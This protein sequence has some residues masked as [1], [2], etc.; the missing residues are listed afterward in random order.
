MDEFK[1]KFSSWLWM[2]CMAFFM[3][4]TLLMMPK[5]DPPVIAVLF[6]AMYFPTTIVT[7]IV[8]LI[9]LGNG[10]KIVELLGFVLD[11]VLTILVSGY[12]IMMI[13]V[14]GNTMLGH[15]ILCISVNVL[16]VGV[17]A[18]K[19]FY[20]EDKARYYQKTGKERRR[21]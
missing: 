2:F 13:L 5:A 15:G 10:K 21:R 20:K 16:I 4:Y 17:M 9:F 7:T 14:G 8:E 3:C 18:F 12:W 19:A 11:L 6:A 1:R